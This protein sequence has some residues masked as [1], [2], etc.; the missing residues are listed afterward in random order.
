MTYIRQSDYDKYIAIQSKGKGAWTEFIHKALNSIERKYIKTPVE[1]T[2][3]SNLG[4]QPI[5]K[6]FSARKKK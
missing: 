6:S 1:D 4:I 5:L 3:I 2:T